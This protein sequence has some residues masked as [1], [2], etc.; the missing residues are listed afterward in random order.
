MGLPNNWPQSSY[1]VLGSDVTFS[2]SS[3]SMILF[4]D[5]F[6]NICCFFS[7]QLFISKYWP[8]FLWIHNIYLIT[9]SSF[10]N[11]TESF[12]LWQEQPRAALFQGQT[13]VFW[14]WC[15]AADTRETQTSGL[16]C[17]RGWPQENEG[18]RRFVSLSL[19]Q[20]PLLLTSK[21]TWLCSSHSRKEVWA[22]SAGVSDGWRRGRWWGGPG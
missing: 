5:L 15:E 2:L 9:N 7:K 21:N 20:P 3:W 6:W 16:S 13:E 17:W 4:N 19:S 22:A 18:G 14:D 11:P 1:M 12:P 8:L 10:C